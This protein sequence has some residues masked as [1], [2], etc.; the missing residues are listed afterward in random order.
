MQIS[1]SLPR[2]QG[3]GNKVQKAIGVGREFGG[4]VQE[5]ARLV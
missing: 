2:V 1:N 4:C 3:G 5:I